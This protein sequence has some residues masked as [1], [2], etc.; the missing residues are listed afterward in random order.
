MKHKFEGFILEIVEESPDTP[1]GLTIEGSAGFTI[2]LPKSGAFHHYPLNE[3]GVNVVMFK[4]DNSTKTPPEISFQLTD[5][6]LE[7][8]KRVS[9]LP[10]LG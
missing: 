1:M 9:V 3:G 6:E 8:L 10:V 2:E 4:M 5:V 7:E